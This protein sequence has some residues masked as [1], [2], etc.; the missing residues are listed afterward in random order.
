[1]IWLC[2]PHDWF[3]SIYDQQLIV[4]Q[5]KVFLTLQTFLYAVLVLYQGT[6]QHRLYDIPDIYRDYLCAIGEHILSPFA[7]V[8]Q[9][10]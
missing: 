6:F 10:L 1:V 4:F 9:F 7:F 5:G 8:P 2:E 3:P